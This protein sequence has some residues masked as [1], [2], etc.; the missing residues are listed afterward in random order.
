MIS[1]G[2]KIKTPD[3]RPSH[4]ALAF[5]N[6]KNVYPQIRISLVFWKKQSIALTLRSLFSTLI[7]V[8]YSQGVNTESLT[9]RDNQMN[10][11]ERQQVLTLN[12]STVNIK[13][14]D[15]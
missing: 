4:A 12:E 13:C 1:F 6:R 11:S 2:I 14:H 5:A 9:R 3:C 15:F 7:L 8:L 10:S